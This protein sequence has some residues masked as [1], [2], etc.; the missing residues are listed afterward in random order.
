[1]GEAMRREDLT[2]ERITAF[3]A[4]S[5]AFAPALASVVATL[6]DLEAPPITERLKTIRS[7]VKK[8]QR[9]TTRLS[10]VQDIVG[11]RLVVPLMR[12]QDDFLVRLSGAHADWHLYDRRSEPSHGYRAVHVVAVVGGLPV[13][14]QIRTELQHIWAELSEA[15]DRL[16]EGVKYGSG[17]PETLRMLGALSR[18]VR[19]DEEAD[20]RFSEFL[21]TSRNADATRWRA[22][23]DKGRALDFA[24]D[25]EW[26]RQALLEAGPM[27][28]GRDKFIEALGKR[29][30]AL[31]NELREVLAEF[32]PP[33]S[34]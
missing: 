34:P 4:Y 2:E 8:M 28:D 27:L 16:H 20:R 32:F 21:D 17:P 23:Y 31:H 29:H 11:C 30:A 26:I 12:D 25:N 33:N 5:D 13:E 9:E 19:M 6:Q 14:V 10:Q 1:L 24:G 3:R 15:W 18:I 7:T 22:F